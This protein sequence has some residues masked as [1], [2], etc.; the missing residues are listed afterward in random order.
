M[1]RLKFQESNP[2][3]LLCN[4]AAKARQNCLTTGAET[5]YRGSRKRRRHRILQMNEKRR[6]LIRGV[7]SGLNVSEAGRAAGYGTAQSA[8]RA[9]NLIRMGMPELL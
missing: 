3:D 2:K 1:S 9:M 6:Q 5:N 4:N 7:A 8:H